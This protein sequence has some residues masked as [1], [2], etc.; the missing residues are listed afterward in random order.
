[1]S[2]EKQELEVQFKDLSANR[3]TSEEIKLENQQ[4]NRKLTQSQNRVKELV[5]KVKGLESEMLTEQIA[6]DNI[7]NKERNQRQMVE[8]ELT[9]KKVEYEKR[10]QISDEVIQQLKKERQAKDQ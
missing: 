10:K 8:Q 6:N 2:H 4:L 1:I 7:L 5:A 9:R 3:P